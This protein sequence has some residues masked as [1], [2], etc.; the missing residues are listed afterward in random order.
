MATVARHS[1]TLCTSGKNQPRNTRFRTLFAGRRTGAVGLCRRGSSCS[2]AR[3]PAQD[4]GSVHSRPQPPG[5]AKPHSNACAASHAVPVAVLCCCTA[6][7]AVRIMSLTCGAKGTRTPDPL[8]QSRADPPADH[9]ERQRA[10]SEAPLHPAWAR[11]GRGHGRCDLPN[12][13]H[14][15]KDSTIPG[16][17]LDQ[18]TGSARSPGPPQRPRLA[19]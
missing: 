11:Y 12:S 5:G 16:D 4:L 19:R 2:T 18:P 10:S 13:S 1:L 14:L 8:L 9:A 7:P 17:R 15:I 6:A 3:L